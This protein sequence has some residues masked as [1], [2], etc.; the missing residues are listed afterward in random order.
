MA[1]YT[2]SAEK[3]QTYKVSAT[4]RMAEY[5]LTTPIDGDVG[6]LNDFRQFFGYMGEHVV[7][8]GIFWMGCVEVES[9][10]GTEL[11]IVIYPRTESVIER[12]TKLEVLPSPSIPAPRGDVSGNMIAIPSEA[13][14]PIKPPFCALW[15]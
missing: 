12:E 15:I 1:T 2:V 14:A 3:L 11:P 7:M 8:S 4:H 10:P 9:S 5:A 13:A 6:C